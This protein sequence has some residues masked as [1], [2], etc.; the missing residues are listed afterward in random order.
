MFSITNVNQFCFTKKI[1]LAL[2]HDAFWYSDFRATFVFVK[3]SNVR[4]VSRWW[5]I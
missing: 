4:E 2:A 3:E 5:S 1:S